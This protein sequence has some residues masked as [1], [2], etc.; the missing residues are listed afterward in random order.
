M[1]ILGGSGG[2]HTGIKKA[3]EYDSDWLYISDDDAYL[4]KDVIERIQN[5]T[6]NINDNVGATLD[7]VLKMAK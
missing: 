5:I 4:Q 3:L 2:F 7:R 6:K 1:K